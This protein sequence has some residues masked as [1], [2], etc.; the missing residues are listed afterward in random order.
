MRTIR[1]WLL[2]MLF[3]PLSL[4]AATVNVWMD[5]A[6]SGP[7]NINDTF[8]LN[9]MGNWDAEIVSG[10]VNLEF[11]PNIIQVISGELEVSS[12]NDWNAT[13]D[14]AGGM[15]SEIAFM[16]PFGLGAGEYTIASIVIQAVGGGTSPLTVYDAESE[17]ADW[18][19]GFDG[20]GQPIPIVF[21]STPGT[22]SVSAVP[23]PAAAWFMLS[24]L[25]FLAF[26][27]SRSTQS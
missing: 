9:I 22:V 18:Y 10:A 16:N 15:I 26:R 7:Y 25:G 1:Y 21:S 11:D 17:I 5:P 6:D 4:Q 8:T 27:R 3:A 19:A 13:I 2:A 23:L 12:F 20:S 24:G 14:N